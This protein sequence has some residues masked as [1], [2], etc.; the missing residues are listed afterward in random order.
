MPYFDIVNFAK[1]VRCDT[2]MSVG[3][4][5]AVCPATSVYAAYNVLGTP[6]KVM[7]EVPLGDHGFNHDPSPKKKPGV[8]G[9]GGS[10]VSALIRALPRSGK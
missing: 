2:V 5:D 1:R 6:K 9:Y 7:Y 3:F 4:I 8:F 10:Q